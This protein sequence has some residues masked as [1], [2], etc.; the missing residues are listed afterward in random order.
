M[1]HLTQSVSGCPEICRCS[2]S[3]NLEL[4]VDCSGLG[5]RTVPGNLPSKTTFLNISGNHFE[6]LDNYTFSGLPHLSRLDLSHN[7]IGTIR[8]QAFQGLNTLITLSLQNNKL[9]FKDIVDCINPDAFAPLT[10]LEVLDIS[11]N[12]AVPYKYD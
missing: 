1:F 10:H 12:Y 11:D 6:V 4:L 7:T 3:M 2:W 9:C 8:S 5:L